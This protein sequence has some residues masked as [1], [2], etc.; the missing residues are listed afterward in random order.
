MFALVVLAL[1][2]AALAQPWY[3]TSYYG[4]G[5]CRDLHT[6]CAQVTFGKMP[7]IQNLLEGFVVFFI[8]LFYLINRY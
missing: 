8:L 4:A 5:Y 2:S 7:E 6:Q 3:D 1:V